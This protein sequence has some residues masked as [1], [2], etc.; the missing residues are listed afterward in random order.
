MSAKKP[1]GK[2]VEAFR[3]QHDK[4]YRIPR[5]IKASLAE[6]GEGWE[7]E[8]E[9]LKRCG[10]ATGD[11]AMFRDQFADHWLEVRSSARNTKRVWAGTVKF[12]N[13]LREYYS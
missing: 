11:L 4:T 7:Y 9:F 1:S 8:L 3:Q 12:A 6:L 5:I 13:K 10:L 2:D